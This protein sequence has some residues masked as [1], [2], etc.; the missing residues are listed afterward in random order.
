M[1]T[2]SSEVRNGCAAHRPLA[3]SVREDDDLRARWQL[4]T[5]LRDDFHQ[6]HDA[7]RTI[8]SVRSQLDAVVDE[9][10]T[11]E[12]SDDDLFAGFDTV[13]DVGVASDTEIVSDDDFRGPTVVDEDE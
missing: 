3:A 5:R 10:T 9:A 7:V 13:Q 2:S 12:D 4:M 8:R 6:C 1:S 11:V